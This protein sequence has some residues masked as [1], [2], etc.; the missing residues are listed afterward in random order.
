MTADAPRPRNQLPTDPGRREGAPPPAADR[1]PESR[2]ETPPVP[3]RA[4]GQS[5]FRKRPDAIGPAPIYFS[6]ALGIFFGTSVG[7]LVGY[8]I[9]G[10]VFGALLG[11]LYGMIRRANSRG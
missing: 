11:A 5:L 6:V 3:A 2:P 10:I 1:Q 8:P 9:I 7:F 4:A